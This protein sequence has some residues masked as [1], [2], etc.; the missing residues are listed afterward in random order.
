[1][2]PSH[3]QAVPAV[4]TLRGCS[5]F[6]VAA[7]RWSWFLSLPP[8][9]DRS[10]ELCPVQLPGMSDLLPWQPAGPGAQALQA[11]GLDLQILS[12][13]AE[14]QGCAWHLSDTSVTTS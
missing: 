8:D 13:Q 7:S 4:S 2:L 9:L 11:K 1:M 12:Q 5:A 3:N 14:L 6:A 10:R